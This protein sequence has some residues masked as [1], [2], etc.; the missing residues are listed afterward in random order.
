MPAAASFC[1]SALEKTPGIDDAC[2]IA[3]RT[4]Q[5]CHDSSVRKSTAVRASPSFFWVVHCDAPYSKL[6]SRGTAHEPTLAAT[7]SLAARRLCAANGHVAA[8]EAERD[9]MVA[10]PTARLT[11]ESAPSWLVPAC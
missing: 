11:P 10:R 5:L 4:R 8:Y 6:S 2:I 1:R 9:G 7:Q 3:R